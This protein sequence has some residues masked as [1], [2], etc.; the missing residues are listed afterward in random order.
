MQERI[1]HSIICYHILA[2][3]HAITVDFRANDAALC[4]LRAGIH[5]TKRSENTISVFLS[6]EN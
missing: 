3:V 6:N 2:I 1:T 5:E 4:A